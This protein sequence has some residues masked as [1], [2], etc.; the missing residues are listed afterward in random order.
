L[1]TSKRYAPDE[2]WTKEKDWWVQSPWTAVRAGKLIHIV[3][4]AESGSDTFLH[5]QVPAS[6]FLKHSA[7]LA[8]IAPVKIILFLAADEVS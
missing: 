1:V 2:S 3:C 8:T 5:L 7:Q 6:F 4:E